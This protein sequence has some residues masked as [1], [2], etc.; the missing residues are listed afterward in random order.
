[1]NITD[2]SILAARFNQ[3]GTFSQGDF[4]YG[5]YHAELSVHGAFL[6]GNYV[7][8]LGGDQSYVR[9]EDGGEAA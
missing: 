7:D 5:E 4:N 8:D 9:R 1:M 2:F 6:G 3:P